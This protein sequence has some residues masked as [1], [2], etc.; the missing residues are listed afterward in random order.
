VEWLSTKDPKVY[1]PKLQATAIAISII[2]CLITCLACIWGKWVVGIL[3][4]P[5]Y[6]PVAK[7]VPIIALTGTFSTLSLVAVASV[8][9]VNSPVY[10]LPIY[11][12]ALLTNCTVGIILI[13]KMG[14][15]G[16]VIGTCA[17]ELLI[18]VAWI[19]IG[20]MFLKNLTLNWLLPIILVAASTLFIIIYPISQISQELWVCFVVTLG[21]VMIAAGLFWRSQ[22][23][24]IWTSELLR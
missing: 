11:S 7:L 15:T 22:I 12:L 4:P 1:L 14:A 21:L 13:P 3:Y 20:T 19:L 17:A 10:H 6:L 2:F 8:I 9:I 18:I 5:Y 23:W 16:A 24:G